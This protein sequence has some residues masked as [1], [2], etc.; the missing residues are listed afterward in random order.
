MSFSFFESGCGYR[1][2][3]HVRY[4]HVHLFCLLISTSEYQLL[5][6][7]M[8]KQKPVACYML[9][10]DGFDE[11]ISSSRAN[12]DSNAVTLCSLLDSGFHSTYTYNTDNLATSMYRR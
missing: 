2:L 7:V 5:H 12:F 11:F 1:E 8:K 10:S 9:V 6:Y 3:R 4:V